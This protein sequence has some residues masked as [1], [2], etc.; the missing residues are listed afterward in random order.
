MVQQGTGNIKY[1]L[2][3]Q[4]PKS[5]NEVRHAKK[6]FGALSDLQ[7]DLLKGVTPRSL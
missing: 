5:G 6:T 3:L 4:G 1:D 7:A 2:Y